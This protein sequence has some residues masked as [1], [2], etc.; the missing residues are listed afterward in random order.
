M[1]KIFTLLFL[2]AFCTSS[3]ANTVYVHGIVTNNGVPVANKAVKIF[4]DTV[5]GPCYQL[6]TRY[7]NAAGMYADTLTCNAYNI[8]TV[9]TSAEGCN[10]AVIT[11]TNQVNPNGIVESNFPLTCTPPPAGNC[12]AN[13]AFGITGNA[14]Q[15]TS[16]STS[17]S[18]IS[19]Y[20]WSFGDGGTATTQN[21]LHV[22]PVNGTYNVALFIISTTGCT[23]SIVKAVTITANTPPTSCNA[24]FQFAPDS[25]T[26]F[27]LIRF[28]AGVNTAYP[29]N[30]PVVERKWRFGDGD[31]L[32]GNVQNPTH[33]YANAGTYTVCLRVKTQSGC[34]SELCKTVVVAAPTPPPFVCTAVAAFTYV[35]TSTLV[36][37][38]SNVSVAGL[39][40]TIISRKW[41]FG[42]SSIL[43]GNIIDPQHQYAQAGIYNVCLTIKTVK[44]CERTYCAIVT[45]TNV[46]GNCVPQFTST[47]IAPKKVSF[48]STMSWAPLGDSI[49]ER[50]WTFG[51][52]TSLLGNNPSPSHEYYNLGIYTVCLKIR[53]AS[54]CQSEV[55]KPV[56]LQDS[57]VPSATPGAINILS[58]Y[59][60]PVTTQLTTVVWSANS[61]VTAE[62]AIYDIYGTKKW[63]I[64]KNLLQGNNVTV[65]P[66]SFLLS[67]P[68]FFKVNTVYGVKTRSFYKL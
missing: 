58:L 48:N 12:L 45:A 44:G 64:T 51:D 1:K 27:K 34:I 2:A 65:I 37:F 10:G 63:S 21:P 53:T 67:G 22:Y 29:S 9:K 6:H 35:P 41:T 15:F 4:T 30:D 23:D 31:S 18:T 13:Y 8:N 26:N 61:N 19:N 62:L 11:F 5:G 68:Y 57:I 24:E 40:D 17:S 36:K 32:T 49:V 52:G 25:L 14:V 33:L 7:T 20:Y 46:N 38:N 54:G 59:P 42:D 39:N 60:N 55:C 66:T 56:V 47:R 28:Y 50:K 16:T 43:T 3:F